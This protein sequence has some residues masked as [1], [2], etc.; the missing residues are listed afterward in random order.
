M[1]RRLV[2]RGVCLTC[3]LRSLL[4]YVDVVGDEMREEAALSSIVR[5]LSLLHLRRRMQVG[6][7]VGQSPNPLRIP[8]VVLQPSKLLKPVKRVACTRFRNLAHPSRP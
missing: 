5:Q 4:F 8:D 6:T 1:K 3:S 2:S 7:V